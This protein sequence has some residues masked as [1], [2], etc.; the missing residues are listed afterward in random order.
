MRA[1]E[2]KQEFKKNIMRNFKL[3]DLDFLCSYFSIEVHQGKPQIALSY[4]SLR[5]FSNS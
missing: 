5:D 4:F 2:A 3:I 1:S